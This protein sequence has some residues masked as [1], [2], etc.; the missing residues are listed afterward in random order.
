LMDATRNPGRVTAGEDTYSHSSSSSSIVS[1]C[2][3]TCM[4]MQQHMQA[5]AAGMRDVRRKPGH[6]NARE[7]AVSS[8]SSSNNARQHNRGLCSSLNG[9]AAAHTHHVH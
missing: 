1:H 4:S 9:L 3:R 7:D 8:S 2:N 6:A 5:A